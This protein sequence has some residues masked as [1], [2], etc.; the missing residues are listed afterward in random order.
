MS[1]FRGIKGVLFDSGYTLVQPIGGSWWP[2]HFFHKIL[3]NHNI[4]G[5][6]WNRL[7]AALEVGT[8]FL[9]DNHHLMTEDHEREQ[10]RNF[11][12]IVL[13][14]LGLLNP[15]SDLLQALANAKVDEIGFELFDDSRAV[16]KRLHESGLSLGIVSDAWPSLEKK[17]RLLGL[18]HYF[19][20]FVISA[21]IG[22]CKPNE[23]NYKTAID[24]LGLPPEELLFVDDFPENVEKAI[25]LGLK[26]ILMVRSGTPASDD[27]AWVKN[28]E[29]I[30]ALL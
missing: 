26:G 11:Y 3:E 20:T 22:S 29:E 16:I 2:G 13:E 9:D 6:S 14:N 8:R 4:R 27:I 18:R 10:F 28:L 23:R 5:L 17:Y 24:E 15:D 12:R 7:E 21:R 1:Q 25:E 19:K 30:E